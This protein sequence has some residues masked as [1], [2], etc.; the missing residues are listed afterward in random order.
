M[1]EADSR[2]RM[3]ASISGACV[4]D[5]TIVEGEIA[6]GVIRWTKEGAK[7]FANAPEA[8]DQPF[9]EYMTQVHAD[10]R[11]RA[12]SIMQAGVDRRDGYELE[13]RLLAQDGRLAWVAAKAEIICDAAGRPC[14]TLGMIWDVTWRVL[15]EMD[16]ANQ[17]TLAAVTLRAIGD[18]VIRTDADGIVTFMNRAA[19]TLTLWSSDLA[20]GRPVDEIMPLLDDR[21]GDPMPH[22]VHRCLQQLE[23]LG[24]SS[25]SQLKVREERIID[26][27]EEVSPI[28]SEGGS[29]MG[30]V[31][32]FRDVS[33]GRR[34]AHQLTWQA[35]HDALTG[36]VNRVEF[37]R[38]VVDALRT[39]KESGYLHAILYLDLDRFKVVNDTCGHGAG[40]VL[41]QLLSKM[42]HQ[43][44]RE[45]DVLARL[46]GDEL[47]ALLLHCAPPRALSIAEHLL[48]AINDFRFVW[49]SRTFDLGASI[50]V[51]QINE[52]SVSATE[53]LVAAD[54]ACYMAKE[55]GRNRVHV[56][57]ESDL[58]L[59]QRKGEMK[60]LARLQE[61]IE[62]GYFRLYS[63]P[64]VGLDGVSEPH[65]EVLLRMVSPAG[66]VTLPGAFIPAAERYNMMYGIDRW[67]IQSVCKH[68]S[69]LQSRAGARQAAVE[70]PPGSTY[71]INLSGVSLSEPGL[72]AYIQEQIALYG[73]NP[74][75]LCFE[76]TET[77]VI[78]NLSS[79]QELMFRLKQQGC[80]FSL[81]DFGNGLSSFGYLKSL[82]VD[83]LKID[84]IFV[85]DIASNCVNHAMVKAI[86]EV[87][88][89]MNIKTVAEFVENDA[90]L[91]VVKAIGVDFAQG[92]AVGHVRR[93]DIQEATAHS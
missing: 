3:A 14:R 71:S 86:N 18:A 73:V 25:H 13:Y 5:S 36:L 16:K 33:H 27:E 66:E 62:R 48:A 51:V 85:R 74:R 69:P 17:E 76:I 29:L 15:A 6:R 52:D 28:W 24:V 49:E 55:N 45:S 53:L 81:D 79:A 82:P 37:E 22:P 75:R 10:D 11:D 8:F 64:I 39:A 41:L 54:Q 4:W 42:L 60:W 47:G 38:L 93:M 23:S 40:D 92:H 91:A 30:A 35:T 57:R 43:Q 58:K 78:A 89:V 1:T 87:G 7:L 67:V 63:M 88:H 34:L 26:I 84:G 83:Y 32:V 77:A 21:S 80:R 12:H 44:M 50:G 70:A 56:Y 46:G 20:V 90:T 31:V 72:C 59:A 68:L 19:E 9:Q 61:A 2:L 65:D